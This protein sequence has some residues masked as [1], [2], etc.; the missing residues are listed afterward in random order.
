MDNGNPTENGHGVDSRSID[1]LILT[2]D[3]ATDRLEI[4]GHANSL[5]LMLDMLSRATRV[6][7]SKWRT[8][9]AI[10]MQRALQQAARD[11]AIAAQ[12]RGG[13]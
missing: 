1:T 3:R 4:G 2:Y 12:I 6:L 11:A 13:R 5:D 7:E 10:E 9:R 8:E